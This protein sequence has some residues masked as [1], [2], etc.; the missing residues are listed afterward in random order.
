MRAD[1]DLMVTVLTPTYNRKKELNNLLNSLIEQSISNFQW[2]VIDDGSDDGTRE[3]F[4]NIS[5][6][7][8]QFCLDYKYKSNG[9]K[10]TALNYSHQYIKGKYVVIVDSDDELTPNAIEIIERYWGKYSIDKSIVEIIFQRGRKIGNVYEAFDKNISDIDTI[11]N[12]FAATNNG[13][14]GDHC[15]TIKTD[16]FTKYLFP[17]YRNEKFIGEGWLWAKI[18]GDGNIVL[19]NK[20]IYVCEYL[21]NGLTKS[22]RPLRIRNPRGG[23]SH[24]EVFL[25]K[26]FNNKIRLKNGIL[27]NC[28]SFFCKSNISKLNKNFIVSITRPFGYLLFKYWSSKY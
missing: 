11:T 24:A 13:M 21:E 15:E 14:K 27:Y 19:V 8:Y 6:N 5:K 22:G 20:V 16:E 12:Y 4:E 3:L 10:H 7:Q 2:L 1:N 18:G 28:Y 26:R 17:E 23:M 9:G 25:D